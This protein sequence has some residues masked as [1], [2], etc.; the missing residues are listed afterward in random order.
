MSCQGCDGVDRREFLETAFAAL[1]AVGLAGCG[2]GSPTGTTL[3]QFTIQLGSYPAI[4]SVGGVSVVDAGG[5]AVAVVRT[6]EASFLALSLS[7]PH[8]G[9]R[10][11]ISGSGFS[12]PAHG[13]TFSSTGARTGG[14]SPSDLR[15][16]PVSYDPTAG[17]LIIG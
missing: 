12:C 5:P 16:Y 8:E 11:N 6:G 9:V 1:A 2:G 10:V 15:R 7:C 3:T 17:A 14:P 4:A 13:A